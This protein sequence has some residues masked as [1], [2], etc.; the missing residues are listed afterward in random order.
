MTAVTLP[1]ALAPAD[2]QNYLRT[3][4]TFHVIE[5]ILEAYKTMNN[6]DPGC[7]MAVMRLLCV[8]LLL[9]NGMSVRLLACRREQQ[10]KGDMQFYP[11]FSLRLGR[12]CCW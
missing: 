6:I 8:I 1:E 7:R 9:L 10:Q 12:R 11:V 2:D 4:L 3:G 5:F